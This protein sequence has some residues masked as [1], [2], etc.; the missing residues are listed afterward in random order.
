MSN[1]EMP[2]SGGSYVREKNG[3]L[4]LKE[5]PTKQRVEAKVHAPRKIKEVA[6]E[7]KDQSS[8]SSADK[9]I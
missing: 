7:Q 1:L 4:T 8:E 3:A 6:P 9:E 2:K 5:A